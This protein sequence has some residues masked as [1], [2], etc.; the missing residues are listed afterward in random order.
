MTVTGPP[1]PPS[2]EAL[3]PPQAV[4]L[5]PA[6]RARATAARGERRGC[7]KAIGLLLRQAPGECLHKILINEEWQAAG[8]AR[9]PPALRSGRGCV[10]RARPARRGRLRAGPADHPQRLPAGV[11]HRHRRPRARVRRQQDG[12]P[13]GPQGPGRQGPG[14]LPA[15]ARH[16]RPRARRVEPAGQR[17]DD[18]APRGAARGRPAAG[19]PVRAARRDRAGRR[20]ARGPAPHRRRPGMP[21][22]PPSG[23]S[24]PPAATSTSSRPPTWSSTCC[25]SRPRTTSSTPASTWS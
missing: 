22:T 12:H 1:S 8:P 7:G 20:P 2:S 17:R 13:R 5:S 14:R 21:S 19:R 16:L 25:C 3:D 6:A 18:V 15:Q 24:P 10:P 4:R 23:R 11:G 9:G